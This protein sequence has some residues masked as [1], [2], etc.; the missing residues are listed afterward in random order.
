MSGALVVFEDSFPPASGAAAEIAALMLTPGWG[1]L[2]H[3][4]LEEKI[5][6]WRQILAH[7]TSQCC[8]PE[9]KGGVVPSLKSAGL[10]NVI[11]SR[12]GQFIVVLELPA[13]FNCQL[14]ASDFLGHFTYASQEHDT[15]KKAQEEAC[16][17]VLTFL[18]T[19]APQRMFI[20]P[21]SMGN[22]DRVRAAAE[23]F[24]STCVPPASGSWFEWY[25][26]LNEAPQPGQTVPK[27][28][29][30][31]YIEPRNQAERA[32]LVLD[33]LR[34]WLGT[35]TPADPRNC[36]KAIREQL[37]TLVLP[38]QLK[39]FLLRHDC[40]FIVNE[41]HKRTW[42]F[43][44]AAVAAVSRNDVAPLVAAEPA[45]PPWAEQLRDPR[46]LGAKP[47]AR[48]DQRGTSWW[49]TQSQWSERGWTWAPATDQRGT[50]G[51]HTPLQW[52]SSSTQPG[53][54]AAHSW[55]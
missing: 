38:N 51:W 8:R 20:A 26:D 16:L 40:I 2:Q 3:S 18:L 13:L 46:R 6:T 22:I 35:Q 44:L 27:A 50:S 31:G 12:L 45:E 4:L 5:A 54:N 48:T 23:E 15:H 21:K 1:A 19:I 7:H 29:K 41:A 33:V 43:S 32:Q 52:S 34:T 14:V 39:T 28:I 9:H 11:Q 37:M 47:R 17:T 49:N 10:D 24:R 30:L 55:Q 36:P 42:T 53:S 25:I